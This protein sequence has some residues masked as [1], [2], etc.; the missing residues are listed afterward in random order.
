M[1]WSGFDSKNSNWWRGEAWW[2]SDSVMIWL[3]AIMTGRAWFQV[4]PGQP[5]WITD[6][7]D[8]TCRFTC[9]FTWPIV[10]T[11]NQIVFS[12]TLKT[13]SEYQMTGKNQMKSGVSTWCLSAGATDINTKLTPEVSTLNKGAAMPCGPYWESSQDTLDGFCS[14]YHRISG[15]LR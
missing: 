4:K 11:V 12:S 3:S 8:F 14:K 2:S 5:W 13:I 10:L 1:E 15:V 9:R 6:V 7:G